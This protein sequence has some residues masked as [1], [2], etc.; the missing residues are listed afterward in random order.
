MPRFGLLKLRP[1]FHKL[2]LSP[3]SASIPA[4]SSVEVPESTPQ[5]TYPSRCVYCP[6]R[7]DSEA[8]RSKH[9]ATSR[10]CV[11][12]VKKAEEAARLKRVEGRERGEP[13]DLRAQARACTQASPPHPEEPRKRPRLDGND[14]APTN[15][16]TSTAQEQPQSLPPVTSRPLSEA[17]PPPRAVASAS[18]PTKNKGGA[19]GCRNWVD[20]ATGWYIEPFPNPLAGAPITDDVLPPIDL[21][22]YMRSCGEM[23][24]PDSFEMAELLLTTGLTD[25]GKNRHLQSVLVSSINTHLSIKICLQIIF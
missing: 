1:W 3:S 18:G 15:Q 13:L 2:S 16:Q 8:A 9:L 7:L 10:A 17:V 6:K 20:P 23:G 4:S 24:K 25:A 12:L 19:A 11:A 14:T 21:E 22:I 5:H